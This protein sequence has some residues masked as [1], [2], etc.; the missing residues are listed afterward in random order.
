MGVFLS[1]GDWS[2]CHTWR[3]SSIW[4]PDSVESARRKGRDFCSTR[5]I[6]W[7]WKVII[8]VNFEF[9]QLEGRSLK[10]IRASTE[11]EP[12][13]SAIPVRCSTNWAV[14]PHIFI[15]HHFTAREGINST[16]WPR[17]QCV[18]SHLSSSSIAPVSRR[19]RVRIPLKPWYFSGFFLPIAYWVGNL[20][21]WSL[22]TFIYNR[23]TIW[24]SYIFHRGINCS[25]KRT[26]TSL[27]KLFSSIL[28]YYA[29]QN[30]HI[31]SLVFFF[32]I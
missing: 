7:K 12:V 16:N 28:I 5:G 9:K 26:A 21:R 15:S 30:W 8:A 10:N 18:A 17:S 4:T 32:R 14:K 31:I 6:Y 13:T 3:R 29:F 20:L 25:R 19:S 2:N 1:L 22:F 23:S 24:I 27:L 11:F